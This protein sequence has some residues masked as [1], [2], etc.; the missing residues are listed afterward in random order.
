MAAILEQDVLNAF[1]IDF[2][3]VLWVWRRDGCSFS[4]QS[5]FLLISRLSVNFADLESQQHFPVTGPA[6]MFQVEKHFSM[7]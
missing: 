7:Y 1:L 3:S 5:N 2:E 4:V 6:T